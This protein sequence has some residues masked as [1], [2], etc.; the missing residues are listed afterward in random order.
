MPEMFDLAII[1]AGIVG[2][3]T[4]YQA[5]TEHRDWR[6]VVL[7][8]S[9]V[10][11]GATRHSLALDLPFGRTPRQ[12]W[13][14]EESVSFFRELKAREPHFPVHQ[15]SFALVIQSQDIERL[16]VSFIDSRLHPADAQEQ[17]QIEA[18]YPGLF[19]P[20]NYR[21]LMGTNARYGI[22]QSAA[23][24]LIRSAC[25]AGQ[26]ECWEGTEIAEARHQK[27]R[28]LLSAADGRT[29]LARRVVVATGP[30]I[31]NGPWAELSRQQHIRT[32]KVAALQVDCCP[33]ENTP[34][35]YFVDEDAFLLPARE[36][37]RFWFSFTSTD[38]DCDPQSANLRVNANDRFL[39]LSI[40]NRYGLALAQHCNGARVFCDAY[41]PDRAPLVSAM[42]FAPD[43][44]VAGAGSG[45]GFRLA[46]SIAATAI[47]LLARG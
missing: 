21:I 10:G 12:K 5:S 22:P 36:A 39:A 31:V 16:S 30:W 3:A 46:P 14:A 23:S 9:M 18:C 45:S 35:L 38:W 17:D 29:I 44:V 24:N 4:A 40:L 7:E 26:V 11:N 8:K 15:I 1:G 25:A 47:R 27:Q 33:R 13:M 42:S 34:V 20:E 28:Y 2:A 32:K 43:C 19:V 6:V 41:S 37:S